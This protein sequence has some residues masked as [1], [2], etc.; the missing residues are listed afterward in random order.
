MKASNRVGD[1]SNAMQRVVEAGGYSVVR[2]LVGHGIGRN[3]HEEPQ[4]PNY[5]ESGTGAL[6]KN[7]MV[8]AIEPMVNMG[9]HNVRTLDD[10]WTVV[11]AD[12]TLS[13]HFEH[14]VAA[15]ENGPQVLTLL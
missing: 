8:F 1:I 5:G 9:Q 10:G 15:S 4:I 11:T 3:M 6:I 12:G 13:C 2:E 14:T 7:G